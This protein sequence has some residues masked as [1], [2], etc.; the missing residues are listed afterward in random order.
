M[1]FARKS[2]RGWSLTRRMA[3]MF[4]ITTSAILFLYGLFSLYFVF[5]MVRR[6]MK[7]FME[8]ELTELDHNLQ[9]SGW[10]PPQAEKALDKLMDVMEEDQAAAV[11]IRSLDGT[12]YAEKGKARLLKAVREAIEPDSRWREHLFDDQ[13]ATKAIKSSKLPFTLEIIVDLHH[14]LDQLQEYA[15]AAILSFIAALGLAALAGFSTSYRGLASLRDVAAQAKKLGLPT[16]G[17]RIHVDDAPIEIRDVGVALNAML[18]RIQ[19]GLDNIRTFTAGLAHELR[20]PLMNLIGET[21][22]TLLAPR[23]VAEYEELLR[24]NLEDLHY[25]SETVDNL[26]AYCHTSQPEANH[27]R[28]EEFD[29]AHEAGLRL[30][31]MRRNAQREGVEV[32]TRSSGSTTLQADREGCLRVLRNLV[33]NAITWS[34][35]GSKVDVLIEG[36][37]NDV[38]I[39]VTDQ[40][41]GV[42]AELGDRI[43]EPFVSGRQKFGKRSGYGLGLAI[44]KSVMTEHGGSLAYVNRPGGGA[45]FTAVFPR[46][47]KPT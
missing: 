22:V 33:G 9:E 29:L 4:A 13:V 7:S 5:D 40:G 1:Q 45:Q 38:R 2:D 8:H 30:E 15:V 31:S 32:I 37:E 47:A 42:P 35:A 41:P 18:G 21:E 6:N 19:S 24:S 34:P 20:S 46:I 10:S 39:I 43:F 16:E 17:E 11:R 26:V 27:I 25:L 3:L 12:L 23:S 14:Q 28:S 36:S 44:C